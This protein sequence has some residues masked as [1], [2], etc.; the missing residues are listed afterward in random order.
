[1][2][3]FKNIDDKLK[4]KKDS[5]F[6]FLDNYK[7]YYPT[8]KHYRKPKS[9]IV[10]ILNCCKI[11]SKT[12]GTIPGYLRYLGKDFDI[13]YDLVFRQNVQVDVYVISAQYG[14]IPFSEK[15]LKYD[16]SFNDLSE[17]Q[18]KNLSSQFHI[19]EDLEKVLNAHSLAFIL[20]GKR[21]GYAL[22]IEK[23]LNTNCTLVTIG[24]EMTKVL[25]CKNKI[26]IDVN[27]NKLAKNIKGFRSANSKTYVVASLLQTYSE[28]EIVNNTNLISQYVFSLYNECSGMGRI[29]KEDKKDDISK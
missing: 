14:L 24:R 9:K 6:S 8:V 29:F 3:L 11:K 18:I 23:E 5:D 15:I 21:Y 27:I 20:F 1:M 28:S 2:G 12:K 16:V 25:N 22:D 19:R 10:I 13:I 17:E 7:K 26:E 4:N